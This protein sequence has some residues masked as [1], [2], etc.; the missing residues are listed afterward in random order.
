MNS[1]HRKKPMNPKQFLAIAAIGIEKRK[2]DAEHMSSADFAKQFGGVPG[3]ETAKNAEAK[4][5]IRMPKKRQ[6]NKVEQAFADIARRY[7]PK[8]EIRYEA[9]TLRVNSGNYTPD[10]VIFE[11]SRIICLVECK[12]P[13]LHQSSGGSIRAFKEA[14]AMY[15]WTFL[16]A[17]KTKA[18]WAYSIPIESIA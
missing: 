18:G 16:F 7:W 6:A 3:I 5:Q 9:L 2:V 14:C 15:P 1:S 17:Q 8:A 12:G 13:Y 10:W 4:P 11:G